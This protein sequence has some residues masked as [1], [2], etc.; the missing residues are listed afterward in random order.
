MNLISVLFMNPNC[1]NPIHIFVCICITC[2]PK[3]TSPVNIFRTSE[4]Q[5]NK[6]YCNFCLDDVSE[7][8]FL[9]I[10]HICKIRKFKLCKHASWHCT[11]FNLIQ[12]FTFHFFPVN[13]SGLFQDI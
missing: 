5:E 8:L 7:E 3:K 2:I 4:N 12:A 11:F 1:R 10:M 6:Y 9:N 13:F